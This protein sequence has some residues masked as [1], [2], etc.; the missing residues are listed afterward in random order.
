MGAYEA[1]IIDVMAEGDSLFEDGEAFRLE[2]LQLLSADTLA[3]AL[4]NYSNF[5]DGDWYYAFCG[6]YAQIDENGYCPPTGPE[7]DPT[8]RNNFRNTL[9]D[10]VDLYRVAVV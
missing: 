2:N 8:P 10:A 4:K 6:D 1:T 7:D 3:D 5:N 9:L